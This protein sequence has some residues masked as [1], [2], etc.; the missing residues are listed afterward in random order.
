MCIRDRNNLAN[1]IYIEQE[2]NLDNVLFKFCYNDATG[3]K[4]K[5]LFTITA[6]SRNIVDE[7]KN[8]NLVNQ[9]SILLKETEKY[10]FSLSIDDTEELERLDITKEALK[11]YFSL[12]YE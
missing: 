12:I 8:I 7:N 11:D 3:N 4:S 5:P 6:S 9:A 10:N 2:Q 1:K